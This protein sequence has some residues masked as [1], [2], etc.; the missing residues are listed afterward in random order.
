MKA[1]SRDLK[2]LNWPIL[3]ACFEAEWLNK[4]PLQSPLPVATKEETLLLKTSL[5]LFE[6]P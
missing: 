1:Q 5:V 3:G 4:S 2:E 6:I